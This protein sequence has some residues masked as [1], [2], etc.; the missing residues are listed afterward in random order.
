[1]NN[2][3]IKSGLIIGVIGIILSMLFYLID[4]TLLAKWWLMMILGVLNL[5]LITVFGVKYRNELGEYM[6]FKDAYLYSITA[7][8]VMV[9]LSTLFSL[10]FFVVIDPEVAEIVADASV[11]NTESMM[12][13]FGAPED[14]MDEALEKVRQDTLDRF[15]VAGMI[16]GGGI[17]ILINL[18]VCL[19]LAVIIRKKEPEFEG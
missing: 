10:V 6:S 19:I 7:M 12:Q 15:T 9:V 16:K 17:R 13:R 14:G 8:G 1:M 4:P 5:V 18:I 11:A 2:H 3:A